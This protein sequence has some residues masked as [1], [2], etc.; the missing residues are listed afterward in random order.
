MERKRVAVILLI[1]LLSLSAA[2]PYVKH[3]YDGDTLAMST[4]EQV[5]YVGVDT[6]EID[7]QGGKSDFLAHEARQFNAKLV[8]GK[9]IRLEFDQERNDHHGVDFLL[10]FFWKTA[11]WSMSFW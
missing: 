11:T 8:Q 4:G 10:M 1:G 2:K 7:H 3:V 5:R 6:P 9:Q